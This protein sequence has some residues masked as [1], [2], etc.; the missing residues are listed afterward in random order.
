MQVVERRLLPAE[1]ALRQLDDQ[2][3]HRLGDG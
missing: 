1:V 2:R 3:G